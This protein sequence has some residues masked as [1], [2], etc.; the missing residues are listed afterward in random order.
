MGN[1]GLSAAQVAVAA[2]GPIVPRHLDRLTEHTTKG[3][4]TVSEHDQILLRSRVTRLLRGAKTIYTDI[5]RLASRAMLTFDAISYEWDAES[6]VCQ[7]MVAGILDNVRAR[8]EY[9]RR[10]PPKKRKR[11]AMPPLNVRFMCDHSA[12]L[13]LSEKQRKSTQIVQTVE[14]ILREVKAMGG[15]A[16]NLIRI[17]ARVWRH[18]TLGSNHSKY[19][20]QDGRRAV[21][22]GCNIDAFYD[23]HT[24]RQSRRGRRVRKPKTSWHD[25]GMLLQGPVASVLHASY[26]NAWGLAT[27]AAA[28]PVLPTYFPRRP[29]DSFP[30]QKHAQRMMLASKNFNRF[31]ASDIQNPQDVSWLYLMAHAQRHIY[32]ETPNINDSEFQLGILNAVHRGVEVRLV[33]AYKAGDDKQK[34]RFVGGGTNE[35]IIHRLQSYLAAHDADHAALFKPRWYSHDGRMPVIGYAPGQTHTKFM[36]VDGTT[37]MSGSGNQDTQSWKHSR[38]TNLVVFSKRVTRSADKV[39]FLHDWAKAV[40]VEPPQ[41]PVAFP[42]WF[43]SQFQGIP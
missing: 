39:F 31:N 41:S 24:I 23:W 18:E 6:N 2:H 14:Q 30:P 35:V 9:N 43:N 22:T 3:N 28:T 16:A 32:I 42:R 5:G 27:R 4:N 36:S 26:N 17:E 20:I 25:T 10:I 37:F 12:L 13:D 34:M 19:F 7:L 33:T 21:L 29:L 40:D 11:K 15:D 1:T 38:E 8:A